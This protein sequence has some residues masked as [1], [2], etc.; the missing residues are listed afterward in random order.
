MKRTA[1]ALAGLGLGLAHA[2]PAVTAIGFLRGRFAPGLAGRGR[3]DHVALTF[4]DGPHP[5]ATPRLL[6]IL[7]RHQVRATF[8]LLG[9][10][11][12]RDPGVVAEIVAAGH[13]VAL[14][15]YHHRCLALRGPRAT[16][17]DLTRGRDAVADAAGVAP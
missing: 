8:F 1:T 12:R 13:E 7:D 6:E 10:E 16:R 2:L 5:V 9:A 4:D 17:D 14:H 3:P 15:G 11:V